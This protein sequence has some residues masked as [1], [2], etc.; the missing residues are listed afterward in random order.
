MLLNKKKK[1]R[2]FFQGFFFSQRQTVLEEQHPVFFCC[3][4]STKLQEAQTDL[5]WQ[6]TEYFALLDLKTYV[7]YCQEVAIVFVKPVASIALFI[8]ESQQCFFQTAVTNWG[9]KQNKQGKGSIKRVS[10]HA[11]R[12]LRFAP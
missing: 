8:L 9:G 1:K 6:E 7:V 11:V 2:V 12:P 3:C 10:Y 5:E 4:C